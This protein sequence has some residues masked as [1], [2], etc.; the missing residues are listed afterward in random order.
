[1]KYSYII[2]EMVWSHSRITTYEMCPYK[3]FLTYI[4]KLPKQRLFFSDYG[5]YAHSIIE[6][7][8]NGELTDE[9]LD[10]YYLLNFR[11]NV[12]GKA[13]N[14][15]IFQNY[16][17]QGLS[18]FGDFNFPY[19]NI[20]DVEANMEFSI[21]GK[22]FVG[23]ID[24]VASNDGLIIID[25]K[26]RNLKQR[27]T[28]SKQT[29]SDIELDKYLR[30]LYLYSIPLH[31]KYGSYPKEL[32]F[33][34]FRNSTIIRELFNESALE[35][36]KDWALGLIDAIE[37]ESEWSPNMEYFRCRYLCDVAHHCEYNCLNE[38]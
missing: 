23:I 9:E 28:R 38:R 26:S 1:M 32:C 2:N 20:L 11:D 25:N 36:T 3:F 19:S 4:L 6:K 15:K 14:T 24:A 31:D 33:N 30:Q 27:S 13:P 35:E 21:C 16:F 37:Q 34:C 22:N 18:Y 17:K 10:V 29:K 12:I 8:L 7:K 5:S